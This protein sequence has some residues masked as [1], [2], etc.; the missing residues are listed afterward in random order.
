MPR[1]Y[2]SSYNGGNPSVVPFNDFAYPNA[3]LNDD[4]QHDAQLHHLSKDN[5]TGL[6]K[7]RPSSLKL[8]SRW[9]EQSKPVTPCLST[10]AEASLSRFEPHQSKKSV[11]AATAAST[12]PFPALHSDATPTSSS[13]LSDDAMDVHND[14]A[15]FF[16]SCNSF[17]ATFSGGAG[18][19]MSSTASPLLYSSKLMDNKEPTTAASSVSSHA[20]ERSSAVLIQH[21]ENATGDGVAKRLLPQPPSV[22]RVSTVTKCG[23]AATAIAAVAV[24]G[25]PHLNL[26]G[27]T[28]KD[29]DL[30]PT[31]TQHRTSTGLS[32]SPTVTPPDDCSRVSD[33]T[34]TQNSTETVRSNARKQGTASAVSLDR[35]SNSNTGHSRGNTAAVQVPRFCV[36]EL[37]TQSDHYVGHA[38][39]VPEMLLSAKSSPVIDGGP[40]EEEHSSDSRSAAVRCLIPAPPSKKA[41]YDA[42]STSGQALTARDGGQLLTPVLT[43]A[44]AATNRVAPPV[45]GS[46]SLSMWHQQQHQQPT[47]SPVQSGKSNYTL[48]PPRVRRDTNHSSVLNAPMVPAA[49]PA[50]DTTY[51]LGTHPG[52]RRPPPP[53]T[54]GAAAVVATPSSGNCADNEVNGPIATPKREAQTHAVVMPGPPQSATASPR[55]SPSEHD[56][57]VSHDDIDTGFGMWEYTNAEELALMYGHHHQSDNNNNGSRRIDMDKTSHTANGEARKNSG[58]LAVPSELAVVPNWAPHAPQ[59]PSSATAAAAAAADAQATCVGD[60]GEPAATRPSQICPF[61]PSFGPHRDYSFSDAL[62]GNR[63]PNV[64]AAATRALTS[65]ATANGSS[66]NHNKQESSGKRMEFH[67]SSTSTMGDLQYESSYENFFGSFL[68]P[69]VTAP[70]TAAGV[71][72]KKT[73]GSAPTAHVSTEEAPPTHV[74]DDDGAQGNQHSVEI[75][76]AAGAAA[77]QPKFSAHISSR[78]TSFEDSRPATSNFLDVFSTFTERR[79]SLGMGAM[80]QETERTE[81]E[82]EEAEEEEDEEEERWAAATGGA[83]FLQSVVSL[84]ESTCGEATRAEQKSDTHKSVFPLLRSV[85]AS[86]A[87]E[88]QRGESSARHQQQPHSAS[89]PPSPPLN[90]PGEGSDNE[91]A[92]YGYSSQLQL[93]LPP[94]IAPLSPQ[95]EGVSSSRDAAAT[96]AAATNLHVS[97]PIAVATASAQKGAAAAVGAAPTALKSQDGNVGSPLSIRRRVSAALPT[98]SP[99]GARSRPTSSAALQQY[100]STDW[101]RGEAAETGADAV[102]SGA[103]SAAQQRKSQLRVNNDDREKNAGT[104]ALLP[105]MPL[106]EVLMKVTVDGNCSSSSSSSSSNSS[107]D[108]Y[109]MYA[110][111]SSDE[112]SAEEEGGDRCNTGIGAADGGN[113]WRSHASDGGEGDAGAAGNMSDE[114]QQAREQ[115]QQ[116][117]LIDTRK[118]EEVDDALSRRLRAALAKPSPRRGFHNGATPP[119][120]ATRSS[121]TVCGMQ[122]SPAMISSELQDS[123]RS[124]QSG[125][126]NAPTSYASPYRLPPRADNGHNL[127]NFS[128]GRHCL[129]PTCPPSRARADLLLPVLPCNVQRLENSASLNGNRGPDALFLNGRRCMGGFATPQQLLGPPISARPG[130][131]NGNFFHGSN[132]QPCRELPSLEAHDDRDGGPPGGLAVFRPFSPHVAQ[133]LPVS[134]PFLEKSEPHTC[135][136]AGVDRAAMVTFSNTPSVNRTQNLEQQPS[137]LLNL[138]L[139]PLRS[140][141]RAPALTEWEETRRRVG[142]KWYKFVQLEIRWVASPGLSPDERGLEVEDEAAASPGDMPK[143][144]FI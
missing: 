97:L 101:L 4:A 61:L 93:Q 126:L 14:G 17:T 114:E 141:S 67:T 136:S 6:H 66:N 79:S 27:T 125:S 110:Y 134:A 62:H 11:A 37:S 22:S 54:T 109:D 30:L 38:K 107:S 96:A 140:S 1:A 118:E 42:T 88:G 120:T 76:A 119:P 8:R 112:N 26:A 19:R 15:Y 69:Q 58:A 130:T 31:A 132:D 25:S 50:S 111:G 29:L 75:S 121:A 82:E 85:A 81:E 28:T 5:A 13:D 122:C 43:S 46:N 115:Q 92:S 49:T 21:A 33:I 133:L 142:A 63:V 138:T 143:D 65:D 127:P 83:D 95:G 100:G 36:V 89:H 108:S 78:F 24:V 41:A 102:K 105:G 3:V 48:N 32:S 56:S 72:G 106:K 12:L 87:G 90:T 104:R 9:R 91:D 64:P 51:L 77:V 71:V 135:N 117:Q 57:S 137:G 128:G 45:Q 10:T 144:W 116:Q 129:T 2:A 34:T 55:A 52:A 84:F 60:N 7:A 53:S 44:G 80:S 35:T 39:T 70:T 99:L 86:T 94:P 47:P 131:L 18:A 23:A 139:Q 74:G 40:A 68:K 73:H 123:L 59:R 113:H 98:R 124:E 16:G 103:D 20:R